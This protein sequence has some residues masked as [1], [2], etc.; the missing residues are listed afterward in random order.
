MVL[1]SLYP[2]VWQTPAELTLQFLWRAWPARVTRTDALTNVLVYF[3]LG[4][5]AAKVLYRHSLNVPRWLWVSLLI[6]ALS[7]T[8]ETAQLFLPAR[9]ASNVDLG[10]NALGGAIGAACSALVSR[11]GQFFASLVALRRHWIQAGWRNN[12]GLILLGLWMFAQLSLQAPALV[13]GELH[14][15]FYPFWEIASIAHF[16][17]SVAMIF[18]FDIASLGLFAVSL[19][20]GGRPRL[21]SAAV[22]LVCAIGVKIFAAALLVKVAVLP[23]VFTLEVV[24]GLSLGGVATLVLVYTRNGLALLQAVAVALSCFILL[25]LFHGA[26]FITASGHMPDL[27]LRPELLL[28]ITGLAFLVAE[29]WPYLTLGCALAL[30]ERQSV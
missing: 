10:F 3:P 6:A 14:N 22:I 29:A 12:A 23:R 20:R 17:I 4:I 8:L 11:R 27:A 19:L 7:A 24:V 1:G 18:A 26:P 21:T 9:V 25:K 16:K 15:S 30:W 2:F 5:F 13:A 28:N